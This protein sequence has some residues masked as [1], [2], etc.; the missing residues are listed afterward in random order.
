MIEIYLKWKEHI[1]QAIGKEAESTALDLEC[2]QEMAEIFLRGKE[3]RAE[4]PLQFSFL[5]NW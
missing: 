1:S 2:D 4:R 3:V 5:D